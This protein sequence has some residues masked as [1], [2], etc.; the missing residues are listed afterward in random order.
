[1]RRDHIQVLAGGGAHEQA[2]EQFQDVEPIQI[3]IPII[4]ESTDLIAYRHDHDQAHAA[5]EALIAMPHVSIADPVHMSAVVQLHQEANGKLSLADAYV[6]QTCRTL[7]AKP[8]A[9]DE[10]I[11]LR[12]AGRK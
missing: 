4:V 3:P 2:Q 6:V 1:L 10:E 7:G 12:A 8:L 11:I 5:L 9:F